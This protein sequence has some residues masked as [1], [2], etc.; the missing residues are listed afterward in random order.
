MLV[1]VQTHQPELINNVCCAGSR[2]LLHMCGPVSAHLRLPI[3]T[4]TNFVL[5]PPVAPAKTTTPGSFQEMAAHGR[6]WGKHLPAACCVRWMSKQNAKWTLAS[7][8]RLPMSSSR[9]LLQSGPIMNGTIVHGGGPIIN[10]I[11]S[12]ITS[13]NAVS[14]IWGLEEPQFSPFPWITV[15]SERH[16]SANSNSEATRTTLGNE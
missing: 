16:P 6:T 4:H 13:N 14:L 2:G 5:M 8:M 12:K 7:F 3:S 1:V 11:L 9:N 15:T 10:V